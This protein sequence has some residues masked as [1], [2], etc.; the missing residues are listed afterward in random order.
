MSLLLQQKNV[1]NGPYNEIRNAILDRRNNITFTK[2]TMLIQPHGPFETKL[3]HIFLM[4]WTGSKP[5]FN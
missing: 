2:Q 5:I 1:I 3:K 4:G